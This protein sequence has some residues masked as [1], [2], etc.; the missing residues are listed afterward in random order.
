MP[1]QGFAQEQ[2]FS[3]PGVRNDDVGLESLCDQALADTNDFLPATDMGFETAQV[4]MGVR[5]RAR[6]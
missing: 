2:G 6:G 5:T 4:L 3:P 1:G